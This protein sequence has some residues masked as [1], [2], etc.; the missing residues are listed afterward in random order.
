MTT[1]NKCEGTLFMFCVSK[2]EKTKTK[3]KISADIRFFLKSIDINIKLDI[4]QYKNL[5]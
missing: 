3:Q 5:D 1:H 2:R 4:N